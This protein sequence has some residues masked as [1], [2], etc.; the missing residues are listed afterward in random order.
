MLILDTNVLSAMMQ[1]DSEPKI[2]Q[3]LDR[4]PT[5]SLWTTTVNVFEVRYGI[6]ILPAGKKRL[7]LEALFNRIVEE[8]LEQRV[9][10]FDEAG[11]ACAA[12]LAAK[13]CKVGRTVDF[14]D[15]MI[16]GIALARRAAIATRNVRHFD[17]LGITI[18]N[19]WQER[20]I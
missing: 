6:E 2:I 11:A 9:L 17:D 18:V 1:A 14:R 5:E 16:G 13:R 15:T 8:G 10:P 12:T 19:P 3:W 20:L 7:K 4:Q